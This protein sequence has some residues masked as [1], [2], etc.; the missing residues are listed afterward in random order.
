[1]YRCTYVCTSHIV[2]FLIGKHRE[3]KKLIIGGVMKIAV[4]VKKKPSFQRLAKTL[5]T[6]AIR[7]LI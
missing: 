2:E 7:I 5:L 6:Q 4:L 3:Q 1:M